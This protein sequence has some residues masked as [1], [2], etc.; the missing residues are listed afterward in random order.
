M[1]NLCSSKYGS[2][3]PLW[4]LFFL[5]GIHSIADTIDS[6]LLGVI[7]NLESRG[8]FIASPFGPEHRMKDVLLCLRE[9]LGERNK[10]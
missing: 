8:L 5:Y 2:T 10:T 6:Q 7:C 4:K 1:L 9:M 3:V